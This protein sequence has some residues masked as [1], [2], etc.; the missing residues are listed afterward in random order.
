MSLTAGTER[1]ADRLCYG[2]VLVELGELDRAAAEVAEILDQEPDELDALSLFAKIKH[3]RGELS[4]AVACEAQIQARQPGSGGLTRMHLE[5]ILHLAQDPERGA[6][7]FLAVGQFQLVP[8][9]TTYLALEEAFRL[10]LARRPNDARAVCRKVAQQYREKDLEVYRLAVM[11]EAWLCEL[12]GDLPAATEILERLGEERGFETH[13]DRLTALAGLYERLGSRE[14]LEAAL[15]I[16]RYLEERLPGVSVLGH[17]ARQHH[18]LGHESLAEEYESRHLVAYRRAMHRPSFA[19][20]IAAAVEHYLPIERLARLSLPLAEIDP[21]LPARGRAIAEALHGRFA[22]AKSLLEGREELLDRKYQANLEALEFGDTARAISLHLG[23]FHADPNDVDILGWLLA[24]EERTHAPSIADA[25]RDPV[26]GTRALACLEAATRSAPEDPSH[27]GQLAVFFA[28]QPGGE[29]E[30]QRFRER[31]SAVERAARDRAR[32]IG[33]VMSPAVYRLMGRPLGLVH[34]V[35]VG[36]E[37]AAPPPGG[38]LRREDV[39]GSVTDQMRDSVR[40]TFLAVREYARSRFP[41][42]TADL[43]DFD[44]TFKV[45]KEDEPSGGT[46]AGLPTA[47]AFLSMFLQ[48]AVPQDVAF[49]GVLVTDAH[50]VINVRAVGDL[51]HKVDAAYHRNLRMIVVPEGNRAH[52][53]QAGVVPRAI[54]SE[55]VRYVSTLEEAI[56][57]V[58]GEDAFL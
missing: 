47:M 39:L 22:Q 23:A 21:G 10:Y 3:I 40:N 55:I 31:E 53:E 34:E 4:M 26:V 8:K 48:R 6:G 35:W 45:T 28:L 32:P 49:T 29:A 46:S 38:V 57:L 13:V 42:A 16:G 41:H 2:R 19:D 58:F 51:E 7:E 30:A 9:P 12:I 24:S 1:Q 43:L 36:R 20:V 33:R 15:N 27:W 56:K 25:L 18:R 17:L 11:A 5:S 37:R 54:V 44:Y 50:D 52:F 14:K